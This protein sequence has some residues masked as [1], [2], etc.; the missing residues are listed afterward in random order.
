VGPSS[1]IRAFTNL[2]P[3]PLGQCTVTSSSTPLF[4]EWCWQRDVLR[5]LLDASIAASSRPCIRPRHSGGALE[6]LANIGTNGNT[7]SVLGVIL[8]TGD[9]GNAPGK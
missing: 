3:C 1:P 9:C 7:S 4:G 6:A 8:A 5:L 2:G